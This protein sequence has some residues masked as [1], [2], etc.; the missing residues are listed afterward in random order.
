MDVGRLEA[1]LQEVNLLGFT[2]NIDERYRY[3][4]GRVKLEMAVLRLA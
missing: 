1:H 3:S 4:R 2:L